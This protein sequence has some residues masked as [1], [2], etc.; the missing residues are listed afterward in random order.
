MIRSRWVK[1]WA[2]SNISDE[3][4]KIFYNL[5]GS[6]R[7]KLEIYICHDLGSI[8]VFL[9]VLTSETANFV[10]CNKSPDLGG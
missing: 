5:I 9:V 10:I 3:K 8:N 1:A 6:S 7:E 4:L 2:I